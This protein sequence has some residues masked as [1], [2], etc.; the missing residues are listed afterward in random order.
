MQLRHLRQLN[1]RNLLTESVPLEPG[2]TVLVGANGAGKSNFLAACYL[3]LTGS[4]PY[5]RIADAIRH[6]QE[7]A[8][9]SIRLEHDEGESLIELGLG[10]GRR[11]IRLDG[12]AVRA[13]ELAQVAAAVL[14]NPEDADM[15]HGGPAL[16]RAWLDSLLSRMSLRYDRLHAEYQKV[17]QQRNAMLKNVMQDS[18]LEVWTDRLVQLGSAIEDL[19]SRALGRLAPLVRHA[20][21]DVVRGAVQPGRDVLEMSLASAGRAPLAEAL[22]ASHAE[23]RARGTTVVGPHRDDLLLVL[24]GHPL[25]AFGSRGEART[26]ALAMKVAEYRLLHERHGEAPVLLLD[27]F[28][29]ELDPERRSFLLQLA[30]SVPQAIAT[31]TEAPAGARVLN[32]VSGAVN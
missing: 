7:G 16:R 4:L 15:I 6:G 1:F 27:D 19:R 21:A 9:V 10:P 8:F 13:G 31:G 11:S 3:G 26:A 29:A 14:M 32:V 25:Q 23:E 30:A 17:L 22:A 24:G 2:L 18:S 28:T 20:Y 5:G 12:N